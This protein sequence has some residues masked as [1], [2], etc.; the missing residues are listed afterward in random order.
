MTLTIVGSFWIRH[1]LAR[2]RNR[3]ATDMDSIPHF[4]FHRIFRRV[5]YDVNLR[6]AFTPE[7]IDDRL[8]EAI[9]KYREAARDT[10]RDFE[11]K[12]LYK[13]AKALEILK[14]KGFA[15]ATIREAVNNPYGFVSLTLHYDRRKAE[16]MR[17]AFERA[18]R[19]RAIV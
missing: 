16:E 14:D 9:S 19:R 4:E 18:R 2:N 7:D 6:G 1:Y 12:R 11:R 5:S 8:E 3:E 17:L 13:K 15:E 10:M